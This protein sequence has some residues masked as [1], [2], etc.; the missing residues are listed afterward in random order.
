MCA[1]AFLSLPYLS[2]PPPPAARPLAAPVVLRLVYQSAASMRPQC[3][4]RGCFPCLLF[5]AETLLP[6]SKWPQSPQIGVKWTILQRNGSNY[7]RLRY[8]HRNRSPIERS[9]SSSSSPAG[10][11]S[12]PP[13]RPP[14][15]RRPSLTGRR[16]LC[17]RRRWAGGGR[18]LH[19]CATWRQGVGL[20]S[21]D[22]PTA[23]GQQPDP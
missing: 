17:C 23:P 20:W 8:D 13:T 18:R 22:A 19:A 11:L 21:G 3:W 1:T 4:L 14:A 6:P 16:A 5:A 9:S 15:T 2:S 7:L 10:T 12:N